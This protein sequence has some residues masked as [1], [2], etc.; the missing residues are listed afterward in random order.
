MKKR[1][2]FPKKPH[3][4]V[5]MPPELR[6]KLLSGELNK[7]KMGDT[8]YHRRVPIH[9]LV[10]IFI[11][12]PIN[13]TDVKDS[14][15]ELRIEAPESTLRVRAENHTHLVDADTGRKI[16]Y[17]I[18]QGIHARRLL[19]YIFSQVHHHE[20][21]MLF[22][23][24]MSRKATL[25]ELGYRF[26]KSQQGKHPIF[27]EFIR[28]HKTSYQ[29]LKP[30]D[31]SEASYDVVKE[32]DNLF[33]NWRN[34][35]GEL[36]TGYMFVNPNFMFRVGFPVDFRHVIG[37][38]RRSHFWNVYM[39]LVSLLPSI[40]RRQIRVSWELMHQIFQCRYNTI[41]NLKYHFYKTVD[42]VCTIYPQAEGK[43]VKSRSDMLVLKYAP[44]P[45]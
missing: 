19:L 16:P 30:G 39:F 29:F 21:V 6:K 9:P 32:S 3:F 43:V 18:P 13:K 15:L 25:E 4:P 45:V 41:E 27:T 2:E 36:E 8:L 22:P 20:N 12:L 37:T 23:P 7:D 44:P 1:I 28:I 38:D 31:N 42:E 24:E 40:P 11:A 5:L 17:G 35:D 26:T 10:A 34:N 33:V 14:P